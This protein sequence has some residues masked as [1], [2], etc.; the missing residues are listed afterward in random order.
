MTVD[1]YRQVILRAIEDERLR[2][3]EKWGDQSGHSNYLWSTILT[4]E[5]G[6]AAEAALDGDDVHLSIE[7]IQCAAVCVQWLEALYKKYDKVL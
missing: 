3:N 1:E 6:E 4:E 2:Q 5:I 7:L